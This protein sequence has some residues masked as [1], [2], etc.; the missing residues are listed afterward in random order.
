ME[1]PS[2]VAKS[3]AKRDLSAEIL[4]IIRGEEERMG[5]DVDV[6]KLVYFSHLFFLDFFESIQMVA[7]RRINSI[8]YN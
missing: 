4:R 8:V 2:K 5:M 3:D 7:L 6:E 1:L